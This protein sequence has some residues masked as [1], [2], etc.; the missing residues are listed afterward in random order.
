MV[1]Q[2]QSPQHLQLTVTD[3][4]DDLAGTQKPMPVD[5]PDY[6]A[7]AFGEL[8]RGNGGALKAGKTFFHSVTMMGMGEIRE[9][10]ELAEVAQ[11]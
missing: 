1:K 11:S 9:T 7:V 4:R 6:G 8:H 2:F 10:L 5:E 3:K